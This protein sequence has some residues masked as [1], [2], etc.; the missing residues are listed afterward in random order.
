MN[1]QILNIFLRTVPYGSSHIVF[2]AENLARSQ[3]EQ[4][5]EPGATEPGARWTRRSFLSSTRTCSVGSTPLSI[6]QLAGAF[7]GQPWG[8]NPYA[9]GTTSR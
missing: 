8:G 4:S 9:I 2:M 3:W 1:K 5:T 7:V 6:L